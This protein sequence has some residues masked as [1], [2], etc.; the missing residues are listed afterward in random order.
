MFYGASPYL[1]QYA[2]ELRKNPTHAEELLWERLRN[3][4][5]GIKFRRQHPLLNYIVDFYCH[6]LKLVIEIDGGY[7]LARDQRE[8]DGYR[9]KDLSD[10]GITILRF[11]NA[12]VEKNIEEVLHE[13]QFH[14]AHR[15][16]NP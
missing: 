7:H 6:K 9:A 12:Q 1:F 2:R 16:P 11:T 13:I 4:K 15:T 5:L 8:Y 3:K 14:I 10:L